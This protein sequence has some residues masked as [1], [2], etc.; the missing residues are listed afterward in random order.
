M[1]IAYTILF[2]CFSLI[3]KATG[4]YVSNSGSDSNDGSSGSPFATISKANSVVTTGDFVY[5][6]KGDLWHEKVCPVSGVSYYAY[7]S[8]SKP[9]ITGFETLSGWTNVGNIWS[10]TFSNSVKYQ[11]T[12]FINGA[13]RAKGRYP[14]TGYLTFTS[15]SGLNQITGSLTGTPDYTGG[16]VAIRNVAWVI[17]NAYITSQSGGTINF[18]PNS[19]YPLNNNYGYIINNISSVLDTLNEWSC[20]TTSFVIKVYALSTPAAK[21]SSI[22]TLVNC[23]SKT[24]I[25][26]DGIE[27]SG[28]NM[29]AFLVDSSNSI[30]IN[31]CAIKDCGANAITG[32]ATN[33]MTVTNDSIMNCW[34]DGLIFLD[35]TLGSNY[36]NSNHLTFSNNYV[37]NIGTSEVMGKGGNQ[38][39]TALDYFG[40][41]GIITY[42]TIKRVG[43]I[44]IFF[45]GDSNYVWRN[46]IDSFCFVKDDG[47]GIYTNGVSASHFKGNK[48]NS[49]Y[50]SNGIG[51]GLG[52]GGTNQA[53]GLY[54]DDYAHNVTMDS[55]TV[56]KCITGG[57]LFHDCDSFTVRNNTFAINGVATTTFQSTYQNL[58]NAYPNIYVTKNI[59]YSDSSQYALQGA[60]QVLAANLGVMDSNYYSRPYNDSNIIHVT[61]GYISLY[62]WQDSGHDAHS[63]IT[64]SGIT[65]AKA[66][67]LFNKSIYPVAYALGGTF[68]DVKG[69]SYTNAID[70]NPYQSV[71]LFKAITNM[72]QVNSQLKTSLYKVQ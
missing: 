8:G 30:K 70:V 57:I 9:I 32:R 72:P 67:L 25:T 48:A 12:V 14:N 52:A 50:V 22:D 13:L 21:A 56:T 43:Y 47:G 6:N 7:G 2:I 37:Y 11:N 51:A 19:Y 63:H 44:P 40:N 38:T 54:Q 55:N 34:N 29:T 46:Y 49:N 35:F 3:T 53:Y 39:T 5:L 16:Q 27:F 64:P 42:N 66:V 17:N 36:S 10:S 24:N 26:F 28:A 33:Y 58:S 31:N 61:D 41:E 45:Q 59:F 68:I 23:L 4:Y 18:S 65:S 1:R 69:N 71:L 15:H 20:D 60:W 62:N